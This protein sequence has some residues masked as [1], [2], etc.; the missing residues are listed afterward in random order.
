MS[1]WSSPLACGSS[2]WRLSGAAVLSIVT[3]FG[4]RAALQVDTLA[5]PWRI[6][7]AI[8]PLPFFGWVLYE[9]VRSSRQLDELQRRIHL[10]ALAI[11]YPLAL[12]LLMTLGL[13]DLAV[14]LN[15]EDWS[16]RHVWQMQGVIYLLS[17]FVA[18]R[19]YGISRT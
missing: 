14:P 11:A 16:Y 17:L 10:E 3:Y 6:G 18:Q 12:T 4:A 1:L 13:L 8:V 15:R 5:V 9:I 19:R 2:S 7:A